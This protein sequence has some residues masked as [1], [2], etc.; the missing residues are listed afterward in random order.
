MMRAALIA[1]VMLHAAAA[2]AQADGFYREDL[3]IPMAEADPN[4]L[5]ALLVRPSGPQRYPL[6]LISHG[7]PRDPTARPAMS[8]Y[9]ML[10]PAIE[11]ARRGFAV[12]V[13]MSRGYG[14]SGGPYAESNGPFADRDYRRAARASAVD[15]R[16]AIEA[17]KKRT[18]VSTDGMI[19]V[20]VSS[21]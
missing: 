4:G 20:G 10:R 15:L 17:M 12:L 6:A 14:V 13:V 2:L 8:P 5:E 19:A 1:V 11:I 9:R 18:D 21:G 16:A 7:T 3:R